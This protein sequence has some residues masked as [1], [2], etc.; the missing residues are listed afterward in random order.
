MATTVNWQA[1]VWEGEGA[2]ATLQTDWASIAVSYSLD[3]EYN[4]AGQTISGTLGRSTIVSGSTYEIR[5]PLADN[6]SVASGDYKITGTI[7]VNGSTF[8][9]NRSGQ[10]REND[11]AGF[12]IDATNS[13]A[14]YRNISRLY[15][16]PEALQGSGGWWD[17]TPHGSSRD[18]VESIKPY[19][20]NTTSVAVMAYQF[21]TG[22]I[23]TLAGLD[24]LVDPEVNGNS[25]NSP[26][27]TNFNQENRYINFAANLG[28][29]GEGKAQF[30]ADYGA[31][32]LR[33]ALTKAYVEIIGQT[34]E[35]S[36]D[37]I[38]GS[39]SYFEQIAQERIGGQS[40]DLA[41]KAAAIGYL[42]QEA[43][44][45]DVGVYAQAL[46]NFYL[47]LAD[48]TARHQVDLVGVYGPGTFVDGVM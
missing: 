46:E 11:A 21:F 7:T 29:Q 34:N 26:Y 1:V 43:V 18:T 35:A 16:V 4:Y 40:L 23:P 20:T 31:L 14:S 28:L 13:E 12:T 2:V 10:I 30:A 24:Y 5:I 45:S 17:L 47:D 9:V 42:L 32:S 6:K 41:T 37:A 38:M 27:Y 39:K 48:G 36:I 3:Y 22:A 15:D 33:E 8:N 19:V 25:L 44:K